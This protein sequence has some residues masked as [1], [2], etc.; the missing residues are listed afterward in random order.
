MADAEEQRRQMREWTHSLEAVI[1]A[2]GPEVALG[3]LRHLQRRAALRG[4]E[5]PFRLNTAYL[6]SIAVGDESQVPGDPEI[7]E[8]LKNLIRWNAMAMVARANRRLD[9]IGGHISTYASAATL[10][11]VGFNHFFQGKNHPDGPDQIYFQGHASPGVY[12]RSFLE[13]RLKEEALE[14]FRRELQPQKGLPSYPHPWLMEDYWEFPTVSMG[15]SP[16]MAVYQARFNHYLENRGLAE[17]TGRVWAFVGDGEMDE[18]ESVGP[19][20]IAGREGLNNLIMVVNCN[21]QRLDGPVT[22]NSKIIQELESLFLGARWRVIKVLWSCAWD[23]LL[24]RDVDGL[25]AARMEEVV[26]GDFQRYKA[27]GGAHMREHFF[28]ADPALLEMV[29]HLTDQEISNLHWGGNDPKK[30]YAAY[31]AAVEEED[32]PTVILAKTVKGFALGDAGEARNVSHQAKSMTSEALRTFRDRLSIPLSDDEIEDV[33]FLHPGPESPEVRYAQERR[34]ELGGPVPRRVEQAGPLKMPD[35]SAFARLKEGTKDR[36]A[37]TTVLCARLLRDLLKTEE[38][39]ELIV[40]VIPDEARTFGLESLFPQVGIYAPGGQQYEPVDS[41]S[42]LSYR[43]SPDGQILEEG[44][45]E[46]GSMCSAIAA[47]TAYATHGVN[48]IPFFFFYSMFGFQRIGDFIWA[49]G[50]MKTRGFLIGA[51]SGRTSLVGEGL[52]HQDGH[53]QLVALSHPTVRA[54]DP[55]YGYELATIIEDGLRK[56]YVD[57]E[58]VLYYLTVTN[59]QYVHPPL[60]SASGAHDSKDVRQGILRGMYLLKRS[61]KSGEVRRATLMASGAILREAEE[62]QKILEEDFGVTT[63]LFSVTSWKELYR[64]AIDVERF[65]TRNPSKEAKKTYLRQ[66]LGEDPGVVVAASDYIKAL[67]STLGRW[68]DEEFITLGTDGFGRSDS[69]RAARDFFEVDTRHIVIATLSALA[70][71]DR[72][73][74]GTVQKAISEFGINL[75]KDNPLYL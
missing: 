37:T 2:E 53:S 60:P 33:P 63:D 1:E 6:N 57:G 40:P 73:P 41:E 30:V 66:C 62:A 46:A 47:G 50:D 71:T 43:E 42:M 74:M 22:G 67:P 34:E 12:A 49:A 26:D 23:E 65:N 20:R 45:T 8:R 44:I 7:E 55:C 16:M 70:R 56:M 72:Y 13:G 11:E 32:R 24:E 38:L 17:N 21:L 64:D 9:G 18:P 35:E 58:N 19:L 61:E 3:I 54:F 29:E 25:L 27:R 4:L 69:R 10:F 5:L 51:T 59:D 52:Q 75:D 39:G 68:I 36:T 28:G 31:K 48:A 14:N 15:L